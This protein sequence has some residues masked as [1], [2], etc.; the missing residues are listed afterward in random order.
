MW[1]SHIYRFTASYLSGKAGEKKSLNSTWGGA[2][3]MLSEKEALREV[4]NFIWTAH[5][6]RN[7]THKDQTPSLGLHLVEIM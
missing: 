4:L 7:K 3:R 1:F 2:R 5:K 6:E